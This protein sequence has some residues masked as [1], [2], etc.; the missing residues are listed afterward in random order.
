LV[1]PLSK[2]MDEVTNKVL[3]S[4]T[5]AVPVINALLAVMSAVTVTALKLAEFAE[6]IVI[7]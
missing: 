5:V 2:I 6:N 4:R 1:D 3:S 7:R